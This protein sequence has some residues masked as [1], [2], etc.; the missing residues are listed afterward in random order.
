M[1]SKT[2]SDYDNASVVVVVNAAVERLASSEHFTN[3]PPDSNALKIHSSI[4]SCCDNKSKMYLSNRFSE[5]ALNERDRNQCCQTVHFQTK[6]PN[7][8]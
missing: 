3:Y 4:I 2:T 8:G 1:Y 5:V 6:N 7:L